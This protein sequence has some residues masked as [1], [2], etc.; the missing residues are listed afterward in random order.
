MG[1]LFPSEDNEES[2]TTDEQP[3]IIN[4]LPLESEESAAQRGQG[5]KIISKTVNY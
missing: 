5:M 3:E 4:M 1:V 2:K